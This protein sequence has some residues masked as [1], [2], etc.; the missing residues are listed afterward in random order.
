[1]LADIKQGNKR[2][3][4]KDRVPYAYW[5]GNPNVAPTRRDLLKCNVSDQNDWDT[6][7]YIQ[8]IIYRDFYFS[9]YICYHRHNIIVSELTRNNNS[10]IR[11]IL[12]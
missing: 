3:K 8:V 7:L 9:N 4:W 6:R 10:G 2:T 1:M 12:N 11:A 5:R